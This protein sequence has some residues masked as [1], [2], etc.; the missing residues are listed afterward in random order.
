MLKLTTKCRYAVRALVELGAARG[1]GPLSL[2]ELGERQHISKR[3]LEHLIRPLQAAGLVRSSRGAVGGYE[4]ARD[5]AEV[6]LR[7]VIEILEGPISYVDCIADPE[8][9]DRSDICPARDVWAELNR[10]TAEALER[11]TLADMI[12][13]RTN[14]RKRTRHRA[15]EA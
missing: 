8:C 9:C 12:A 13:R 2:R 4:L 6:N 10:A 14:R 5:P 11:H 1:Q 15:P 7:R 3:Y